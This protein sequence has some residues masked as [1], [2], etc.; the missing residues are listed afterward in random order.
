M[1]QSL[2]GQTAKVFVLFSFVFVCFLVKMVNT[3]SARYECARR[4]FQIT[5][6]QTW[7]VSS[8]WLFRDA[9]GSQQLKWCAAWW[10]CCRLW[11]R[12]AGQWLC[13][14]WGKQVKSLS[15]VELAS[16]QPCQPLPWLNW[17]ALPF[18]FT[19]GAFS[20]FSRFSALLYGSWCATMSCSSAPFC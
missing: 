4:M 13:Q 8:E 17:L 9:C 11:Y 2:F 6:N 1:T 10:E 19:S 7:T 12:L 3:S 14:T 18:C 16:L 20:F 15:V 5:K